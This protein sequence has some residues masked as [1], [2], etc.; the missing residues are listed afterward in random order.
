MVRALAICAIFVSTGAINAR[1]PD[2]PVRFTVALLDGWIEAR[3]GSTSPMRVVT[4]DVF[5]RRVSLDLIGRPP[6]AGEV[7]AFATDGSPD[8]RERAIDR[9][10]ASTEY[11]AHWANYWSDVIRY[12]VPQ[13]ELTFLD[14]TLFLRWLAGRLNRNAGWDAIVREILTARGIV[15]HQPAAMFVG[16]Q[17]ADPVRLAGETA[18]VFL[19]VQIACAEC[20]DHPFQPWKR[21]QF[22]GLAAFF[23]R[24]EAKLPWRDSDGVEVKAKDKG[25]YRLPDM[26]DPRKKGAETVPVAL[27]ATPLATG[28]S[29][30]ARREALANWMTAPDNPYFAK[31]YVNRVWA[32]LMGRGF[33][34]PVDIVD[35][36]RQPHWPEL[37]RTIAGHFTATGYDAKGLARMIVSSRVYQ[38]VITP[39]N[40]PKDAPLG[41]SPQ[42]LTGEQVFAAL[43]TAIGLP[44]EAG[45]QVK[46]NDAFRFPPP[47][48]G[49]RDLVCD[50]FACDPSTDVKN[51]QRTMP[52]AMWLM[53]NAQLS[54]QIDARPESGTLLARLLAETQDDRAVADA[55]YQ[56]VL[57]RRPSD[58]E[59][60]IVLDHL[61]TVKDRGAAFEDLLWSLVNSAEFTSKR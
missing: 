60:A 51:V 48:K 11:G 40:T 35:S 8:R 12:R 23:A 30:A 24:S 9:L 39:E 7:D 54:R 38:R 2:Q 53:N 57:A 13:P 10:L 50:A 27:Q 29:D 25:E 5:L 58:R 28:L 6:S 41:T 49:T 22:H 31:A 46:H 15:K 19:G 36:A 21:E 20:H 1:S 33:C 4:D 52:Q 17:Q 3:S 18:R 59:I 16:F 42:A 37:H 56:R 14:Y 34:E 47:P 43:A 32:R 45:P 44:N 61:A 55:L 26:R